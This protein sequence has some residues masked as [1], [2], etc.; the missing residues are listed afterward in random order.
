MKVFFF[1]LFHYHRGKR[2]FKVNK[3]TL[4]EM[5]F[6]MLVNTPVILRTRPPQFFAFH[7]ANIIK[8]K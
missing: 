3:G 1:F 5:I 6:E 2:T 8:L 4:C 7:F